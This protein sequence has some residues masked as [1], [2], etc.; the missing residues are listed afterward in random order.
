MQT[1]G[2]LS[3]TVNPHRHIPRCGTGFAEF[4]HN[5]TITNVA[6]RSGGPHEAVTPENM[7]NF[8]KFMLSD[9]KIKFNQL[10]NL[11]GVTKEILGHFIDEFSQPSVFA[12]FGPLR[13]LFLSQTQ[14]MSR[15]KK[16]SPK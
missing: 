16:I 5:Y 1:N 10:V 4:C 7:T 12:S 13:L 6:P 2:L 8:R 9:R 14:N 15:W 11:I 3:N